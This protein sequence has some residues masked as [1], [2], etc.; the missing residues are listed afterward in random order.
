MT[1]DMTGEANWVQA[2]VV[3]IGGRGVLIHGAP[4]AG[5]SDLALRLI[6][7]GATLVGDDAVMIYALS[8]RL[9]AAPCP[10]GPGGLHVAGLGRVDL[11]VASEPVQIGI[12]IDLSPLRPDAARWGMA[13]QFEVLTGHSVPQVRLEAL[14]SSAPIKVALALERW[15]H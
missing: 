5:K 11:P 9:F 7:R 12:A 14:E 2:T 3:A 6:D 1:G 10:S 8:G 13:G 4:W 15:G